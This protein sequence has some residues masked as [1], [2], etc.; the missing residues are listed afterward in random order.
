MAAVQ[1]RGTACVYYV[2]KI[3]INYRQIFK[4]YRVFIQSTSER[5]TGVIYYGIIWPATIESL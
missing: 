2:D 1:I 4:L 3:A 5:W